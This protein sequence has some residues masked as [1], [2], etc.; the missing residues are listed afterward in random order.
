MKIKIADF[1]I[2]IDNKYDFIFHQ[3]SG[4]ITDEEPIDFRV[5]CTEEEI[6]EEKRVSEDDSFTLGYLESVCIYRK[7]CLELPK[8]DAFVLHSAVIE[9]DSQ[10]YAFLAR[11]GVGK[12]THI[13]LWKR[14][15]GDSVSIVNGDK[16]IVRLID[17]E[18]YAYGT[19]WCGKECW[20][21][22]RRTRL[23]ALCFIERGEEN[24]ISPLSSE[25]SAL[26]IMKQVLIPKDSF[27]AIKTLELADFALKKLRK[28]ILRCTI[29]EE[30]AIIAHDKMSGDKR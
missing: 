10:G 12:S 3:C 1:I 11:S 23:V 13:S 16:P 26:K 24:S 30:A 15:Y 22:N 2:E 18:L 14:V 29:S 19:P 28:Y 4:Y 7:I 8:H 5:S 6:I 21:E 17:G 20:Q 9:K 27:G 25:E